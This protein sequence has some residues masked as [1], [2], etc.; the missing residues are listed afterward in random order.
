MIQFVVYG[1]PAPQGS[2]RALGRT[3]SGR[4]II[5]EN[6][7]KVKPWRADVK[8][9]CE[10]QLE[11]GVEPFACAVIIDLIFS[12]MRP[13]TVSRMKRPYPSVAPDLGKLAR[14]T[15]DAIT[16][17]GL[18]IDDSLVVEYGRL[19]KVYC[20]EDQDALSRPGVRVRIREKPVGPIVL[21][22]TAAWLEIEAA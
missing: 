2:K 5:V 1:T 16:S 9:A 13:K 8:A 21:S 11:Y 18:W 15:E 14:S 4:T 10:R 19:A 22:G 12:F 17:S 7:P 20:G 6:S 3:P